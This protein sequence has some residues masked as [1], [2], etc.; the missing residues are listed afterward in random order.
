[1]TFVNAMRILTL[2]L[3]AAVIGIIAMV[4]YAYTMAFMATLRRGEK[5]RGLLPF[6]VAG[7]AAATLLFQIHGVLVTLE[8]LRADV[9]LVD[10]ILLFL[11]GDVILIASLLAVYSY[12]RHPAPPPAE[13][14]VHPAPG[15]AADG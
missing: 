1:M 10:D 7:V 12:G 2:S 6:H 5:H 15:D 3:S 8:R 4:F 11:L 14:L 13:G 9:P